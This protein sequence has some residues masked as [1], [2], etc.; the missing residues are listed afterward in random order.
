MRT[1]YIIK[2][3]LT[4]LFILFIVITLNFFLPRMIFDDP[5]TP[6]YAGVPED[7]IT[8]REQ[9]RIEYGFDKPIIE[10]YL[11]Y[12]RR[13]A[14]LDFGTSYI[15]KAPVF[16]VMFSRI[17]WSLYLNI[18]SMLFSVVLGIFLGA[19]CAKNRGKWQDSLLLKLNTIS[20]AI[21]TFWLALVS[22]IVFAFIIPIF[23]YSGAMTPGYRLQFNNS[24]FFISFAIVIAISILIYI[25]TKKSILL[26][27][28]PLVGSFISVIV[29]IPVADTID[30][31][32]HSILP[33]FVVTIGGI[34]SYALSVR[35][36]MIV[37][38]NEDYILTARAKG[39][40]E[41]HIL[42]RHTF[43][44]ALL[45]LATNF[46]MSFVG[47]FGGS[48]LIEKIFSW[49]GMGQLMVEANNSGDFQLAQAI[50]LFFAVI[51][52]AANFVTD[53]IYHKL[54]PRVSVI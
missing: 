46:G 10:Q 4:N 41:R 47:L 16:D 52:I 50:L 11:I 15:Y 9:I 39:L 19:I 48:V 38:V 43:R 49:P 31:L 18:V 20:T 45:P 32:Y 5:A 33:L 34:I 2:K 29:A 12:L 54:D 1:R 36:S 42:Y 22:V 7:A 30:V 53:L 26:F 8:I 44:N 14:T 37:V 21:P 25:I 28:L 40:P 35:N 24:I 17:P 6:Y 51:T 3:F 27:L 13:I 23:P